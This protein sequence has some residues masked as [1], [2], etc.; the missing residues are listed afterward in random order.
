VR[1]G[2]REL[3][4][5]ST[6]LGADGR[7]WQKVGTLRAEVISLLFPKS[8]LEELVELKQGAA[9]L[10]FNA[11]AH[12]RTVKAE[13][14]DSS[15]HGLDIA[16]N[17]STSVSLVLGDQGFEIP[18]EWRSLRNSLRPNL[19]RVE[20]AAPEFQLEVLHHWLDDRFG[21][22]QWRYTETG[23]VAKEVNAAVVFVLR[24]EVRNVILAVAT[25]GDVATELDSDAVRAMARA[26]L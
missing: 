7:P 15:V 18:D 22:D 10:R 24:E 19:G 4:G 25:A 11:Q 6:V 23:I 21:A 14:A 26:W 16:A 3:V 13:G 20:R 2:D 12:Q 8:L 1:L 17:P 5:L 9:A